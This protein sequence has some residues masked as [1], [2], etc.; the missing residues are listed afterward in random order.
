MSDG[1]FW[2]EENSC[3][4]C[5]MFPLKGGMEWLRTKR[6]LSQTSVMEVCVC[7]IIYKAGMYQDFPYQIAEHNYYM[8]KESLTLAYSLRPKT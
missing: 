3:Y 6:P 1:S 8:I 2:H 4:H 7:K 5:N